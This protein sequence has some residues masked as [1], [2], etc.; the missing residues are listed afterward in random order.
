METVI[1]TETIQ[2]RAGLLK[3]VGLPPV[4]LLKLSKTKTCLVTQLVGAG[5]ILG[6]LEFL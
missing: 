4:R 3:E 2:E 5:G 1:I 6:G